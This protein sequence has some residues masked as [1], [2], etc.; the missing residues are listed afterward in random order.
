M[1]ELDAIRQFYRFNS[2]MRR[3]YLNSIQALSPEERLKDR[4]ASFGSLQEIYA[5][6]LDGLRWWFEFVPQRRVE[7]AFTYPAR[8][9]TVD[10]LHAETDKVDRIVFDFLDKLVEAGLHKEIVLQY[11]ENGQAVDMRFPTSDMLWHEVEEELQHRGELNAL[12]WQ[13]DLEPP[14]G[15]V[16]DWNAAKSTADYLR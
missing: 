11:V 15:Q 6:V 2:R 1:T 5:H 8:E 7:E 12:F 9:M 13:L 4:G 16:E 3:K 10:Q 14:I